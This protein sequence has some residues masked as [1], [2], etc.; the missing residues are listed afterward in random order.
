[1]DRIQPLQQ[2]FSVFITDLRKTICQSF[3]KIEQEC[4]NPQTQSIAPALFQRHQW[5]RP[6]PTTDDAGGGEMSFIENGRVFEKVGVNISTVYGKFSDEFRHAIPGAQDDPSF[7]A[8][9]L[10]LVSH[11]RSPHVPIIHMNIRFIRTQKLWFGGGIDLTPIFPNDQ[12]T[13]EFHQALQTICDQHDPA[14]YPEFK[15]WCDRYFFLPHR[16]EMRGVGGIF[17]DYL[18]ETPNK[19][20]ENRYQFIRDIGLGFPIIY[21]RIVRRHMN[22]SWTDQD[23]HQQLRKRSRYVEF[24]LLYDRGTQFGLKTGGYTEAILMSMPPLASWQID[25]K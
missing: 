18:E 14:Y 16:Q 24:N 15:A 20:L 3:E 2:E 21:P 1:M 5:R 8:C 10:S 11:P 17:C 6:D 9:G 19:S 22:K 4:A 25:V 7:W 13:T 12:D 23:Y